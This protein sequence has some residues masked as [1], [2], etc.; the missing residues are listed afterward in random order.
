MVILTILILPVP[1]HEIS[2][3]LFVSFSVS[4]I[5]GLQFSKYRS[6]TSLDLFLGVFFLLMGCKMGLFISLSN[7]SLLVYRNSTD[8]C[9]LILYSASLLN[10]L[11]SFSRFWWCLWDF[12]CIVSCHLPTVT[13][14]LLSF[15]FGF[16]LFLFIFWLLW[17]GL[18][19]LCWIKVSQFK[20]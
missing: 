10:S 19:I 20:F 9:I 4:L 8:F 5:S 13:V 3:H 12:L 11:M 1:E 14:L 7:S 16:L 15:Q 6:F 18:P 2:F 17:Q